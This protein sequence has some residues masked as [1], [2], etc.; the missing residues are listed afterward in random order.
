MIFDL[1]VGELFTHTSYLNIDSEQIVT[2]IE[3]AKNS[4][5]AEKRKWT[6]LIDDMKTAAAYKKA[7]TAGAA[8][9]SDAHRPNG[10]HQS[11]SKQ[12][13]ALEMQRKTI[14]QTDL[15][16]L[17]NKLNAKNYFM[18]LTMAGRG[19]YIYNKKRAFEV[20]AALREEFASQF[21]AEDKWYVRKLEMET[22]RA[23]VGIETG[24]PN[25]VYEIELF[26][27]IMNEYGAK[28]FEAKR[29][30]GGNGDAGELD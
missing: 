7:P 29:S 20:L 13:N 5:Q 2:E 19:N 4:W 23:K 1:A 22:K 18:P 27:D 21:S 10:A 9:Q 11:Y 8:I 14:I 6:K 26:L 3:T 16:E 15:E 17:K 24:F 28:L 12:C 25:R 30:F